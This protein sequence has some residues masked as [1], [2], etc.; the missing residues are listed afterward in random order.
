MTNAHPV[1]RT[2]PGAS[3]DEDTIDWYFPARAGDNEKLERWCLTLGPPLIDSAPNPAFGQLEDGDSLAIA[4]FNPDGGSGDLLGF[5]ENELRLDCSV[6][7]PVLRPDASHFVLLLQEALRR[8]N[9]IP[10]VP[11]QYET[12]RAVDGARPDSVLDVLEVAA[13]CGLSVF[14]MPAVRNGWEER[15]GKR[16]DKGNAI[17]STLPLS[18]PVAIELPLEGARRAMAAA[19]IRSAA[20]DSLRVATVHMETT[21]G[22]WRLLRTGNASRLRQA[23]AIVDVLN[24]IEIERGRPVF[25]GRFSPYGTNTILAGDF[26]IWTT[27]ETSFRR[28][29]EHFPDS[30]PPLEEGT[31]GPF[32]TDHILFRRGTLSPAGATIVAPSYRHIDTEYGSDHR[33]SV[34]WFRFGN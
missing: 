22:L 16:E 5:I 32:P 9:D 2:C 18:D 12:L 25:E 15:D 31:R 33:P 20:G 23:L 28:L 7:A 1:S 3:S 19:T 14:Y 10:E 24:R 21:A 4:V 34:V 13:Q 30:P 11:K 17:L 6:S 8:S 27:S 29:W 26:N